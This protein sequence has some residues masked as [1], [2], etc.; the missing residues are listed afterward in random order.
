VIRLADAERLRKAGAVFHDWG[1]PQDASVEIGGEEG[2]FR[3]VTSFQ[4]RGEDVE[5]FLSALV[6]TGASPA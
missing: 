5:A 2:L 4:T 1:V 3:L 6:G